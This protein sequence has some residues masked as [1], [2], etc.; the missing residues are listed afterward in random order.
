[1]LDRLGDAVRRELA[2]HRLEFGQRGEHLLVLIEAQ[3]SDAPCEHGAQLPRQHGQARVGDAQREQLTGDRRGRELQL[4]VPRQRQ[5]PVPQLGRAQDDLAQPA[6]SVPHQ[7]PPAVEVDVD[8]RRHTIRTELEE[9]CGQRRLEHEAVCDRLEV[10]VFT[11]GRD[12]DHRRPPADVELVEGAGDRSAF[13]DPGLRLAE[14][15][16]VRPLQAVVC[17]R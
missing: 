6:T 3:P 13:A 14:P 9:P 4:R 8:E 17:Q 11:V 5:L 15:S 2:A 1:M 12:T 7:H 16:R 10:K